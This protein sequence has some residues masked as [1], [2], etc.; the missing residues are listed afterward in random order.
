MGQRVDVS[1]KAA[2]DA[3]LAGGQLTREQ[4]LA[5]DDT[6]LKELESFT[7]MG[8]GTFWDNPLERM[9]TFALAAPFMAAEWAL[10]PFADAID[11]SRG[12]GVDEAAVSRLRHIREV[13]R[14][15]ED[16]RRAQLGQPMPGP[17]MTSQF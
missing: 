4:L 16:K 9:E 17:V 10:G 11:P 15:A 2:I 14:A 5:M 6:T 3:L 12:R 13:L 8:P 1:R 7:G